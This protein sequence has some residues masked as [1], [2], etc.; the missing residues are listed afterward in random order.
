[1]KIAPVV[2]ENKRRS[3]WG[4]SIQAKRT[5]VIFEGLF[6]GLI[7][8]LPTLTPPAHLRPTPNAKN[9]TYQQ[10]RSL[11]STYILGTTW[12]FS[13]LPFPKKPHKS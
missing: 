7:S 2:A 13:Q 6:I 10:S 9:N 8:F 5:V 11:P 4:W 1:M 12:Q 3:I